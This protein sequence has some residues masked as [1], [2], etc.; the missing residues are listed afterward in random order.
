MVMKRRFIGV[1]TLGK[2]TE[3]Q[4]P[5][6][7]PTYT[8]CLSSGSWS[9][10]EVYVE[11]QVYTCLS[12]PPVMWT[13]L[14]SS[15]HSPQQ[16]VQQVFSTMWNWFSWKTKSSSDQYQTL[17]ILFLFTAQHSWNF[18]SGWQVPFFTWHEERSHGFGF[19]F[20]F[21]SMRYLGQFHFIGVLYF[22][23]LKA[24]LRDTTSLQKTFSIAKVSKFA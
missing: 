23:S 11:G 20:S 2:G 3:T 9:E 1:T 22:K 8:S 18:F 16:V 24:K 15:G 7:P 4:W 12:S 5:P 6:P 17:L 10:V 19:R 13:C 14:S 21:P